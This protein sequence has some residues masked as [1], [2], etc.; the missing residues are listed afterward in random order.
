[1]ERVL[2]LRRWNTPEATGGVLI[3]PSGKQLYAL[4]CPW[5]NNEFR[6]SCIP[7]GK[8]KCIWHNSPKFG[9]TY[10]VTGT[11][12]RTQILF[13]VGNYSKDTWGCILLGKTRTLN[14]VWNSR[15]ALQEFFMEMAREPFVLEIIRFD[16]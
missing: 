9:W 3:L 8:Y 6:V 4:E 12:P 15:Q 7:E 10:L 16:E 1:M 13:H 14:Y 2:L 11:E 5:K